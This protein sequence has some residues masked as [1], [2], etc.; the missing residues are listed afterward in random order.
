MLPSVLA[1]RYKSWTIPSRLAGGRSQS[2]NQE[3]IATRQ[4]SALAGLGVDLVEKSSSHVA[5]RRCR[6]QNAEALLELFRAAVSHISLNP[7]TEVVLDDVSAPLNTSERLVAF[8]R[9]RGSVI[10][11]I[12]SVPVYG[13]YF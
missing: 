9:I 7:G 1:R 8:Q 3:R 11:K 2:F 10:A 6:H 13:L 5:R 4:S 12:R